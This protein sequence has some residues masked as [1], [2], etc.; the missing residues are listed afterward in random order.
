MITEGQTARRA[1][2]S[3]INQEERI[4]NNCLCNLFNDNWVW[5]IIIAIIL[6][7]C[8]CNNG[9]GGGIYGGGCGSCH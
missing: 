9:C 5:L 2:P 4:M 6:L 8:C 1:V 7:S 3:E